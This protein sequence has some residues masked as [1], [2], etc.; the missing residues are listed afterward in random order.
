MVYS[1][2][3]SWLIYNMFDKINSDCSIRVNRV[4]SQKSVAAMAATVPTPL[5]YQ[6]ASSPTYLSY[7]TYT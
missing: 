3:Y 2:S 1:H 5:Q 7:V 4:K 6:P